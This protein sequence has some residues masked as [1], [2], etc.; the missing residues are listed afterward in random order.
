MSRRV[1]DPVNMAMLAAAAATA[2]LLAATQADAHAYVTVR[3]CSW[4]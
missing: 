4:F 1:A 3:C 2:L